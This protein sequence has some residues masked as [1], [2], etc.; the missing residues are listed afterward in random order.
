MPRKSSAAVEA[1]KKKALG[2]A[3][4]AAGIKGAYVRSLASVEVRVDGRT[5]R[6]NVEG[7]TTSETIARVAD[8]ARTLGQVKEG[9]IPPIE[10]IV[11]RYCTHRRVSAARH[12][13][14][15]YALRGLGHGLEKDRETLLKR[16]ERMKPGTVLMLMTSIKTIFAFAKECGIPLK[17]PTEG[18]RRPSMGK[19]TRIP[20]DEEKAYFE[21]FLETRSVPERL[22]SLLLIETGAR[23][24][25]ILKV[26]PEN[27]NPD[28]TLAL[29]NVKAR[30][31]Y[32][33][34]LPIRNEALRALWAD[35]VKDK[36]S[37][38]SLF[39][40]KT[41]QQVLYQMR[42]LFPPDANGETLSPHSWRHWKATQMMRAG[43]PIKVAAAVLDDGERT[44][45]NI[46]QSVDQAAVDQWV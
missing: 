6:V 28:W 25:T 45:L 23:C 39:S 42:K 22:F 27:M 29:Y 41:R 46:Y 5:K 40:E 10:A 38:E 31:P 26:T 24:S 19:R 36:P 3:I 8:A 12:Q 16:F 1:E 4:R 7:C 44:L 21:R 9:E 35:F 15:L 2:K 14:L 34:R 18:M 30:R 32:R 17:D 20:T 33:V 37:G 43:V 13:V 11:E